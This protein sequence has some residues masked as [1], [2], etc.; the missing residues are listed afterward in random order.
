MG[1][2]NLIVI[3]R[4]EKKTSTGFRPRSEPLRPAFGVQF[5]HRP[6]ESMSIDQFQDLRK[7]TRYPYHDHAS[8][9]VFA[10]PAAMM[11]CDKPILHGQRRSVLL[12]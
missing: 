8:A 7:T 10:A 1:R 4:N 2:L 5:P 9:F 3:E 6:P 12:N 11:S